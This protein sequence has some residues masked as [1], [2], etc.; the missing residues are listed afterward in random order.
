ML[1]YV[2]ITP[3]KDEEKYIAKTIESIVKQTH[4]PKEYIIV[5]DGSIDNTPIIIN[6]FTKHYSWI[7][8]IQLPT[9][10]N[11][12]EEGS[13][14]VQAFYE[15]Y[16]KITFNN[17]IFIVK[18]DADI[19]LPE[20]YFS[21]IAKQF[22]EN[23]NLGLCGG[24]IENFINNKWIKEI[25]APY[26]L[27]G[28]I[29]TYRKECFDDIGGLKSTLGWDGLDEMT[30]LYKGWEINVLDLWVKQQRPTNEAYNK[31]SLYYRLGYANYKNGGSFFLAV[32]RTFLRLKRKPYLICGINYFLGYIVAYIKREEKNIDKS[33]A[34]FINNFHYQR[35]INRFS[36]IL[37]ND[38]RF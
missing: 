36:T 19:I 24:Q 23:S 12:R 3:A 26:H 38:S 11:K 31:T 34:K 15:G 8:L 10:H 9:K 7:K 29:K 25:A 16:K 28:A 20:N 22:N 30:A 5:D 6:E 33:L 21:E 17:Y 35:L 2:I 32:I 4:K 13:K 1:D 14:I 27:R 37:K 18:L